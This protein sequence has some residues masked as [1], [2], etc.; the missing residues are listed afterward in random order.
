MN[1]TCK[2]HIQISINKLK[3]RKQIVSQFIQKSDI[4]HGEV[5][6]YLN[7]VGTKHLTLLII[8]KSHTLLCDRRVRLEN[9]FLFPFICHEQLKSMSYVS[10]LRSSPT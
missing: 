2:K 1:Q 6:I 4:I 10:T 7:D 8:P 5:V 3:D 9:H